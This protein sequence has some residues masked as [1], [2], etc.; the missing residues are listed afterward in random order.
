MNQH[1]IPTYTNTCALAIHGKHYRIDTYY[2]AGRAKPE[3][4]MIHVWERDGESLTFASESGFLLWLERRHAPAQLTL[5][6]ETSP[7]HL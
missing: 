6:G 5:W 4:R 1:S 2:P 7:S 3:Y